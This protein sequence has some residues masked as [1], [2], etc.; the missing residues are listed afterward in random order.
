[1][2]TT[3][4]FGLQEL[5]KLTEE[6]KVKKNDIKTVKVVLA[7]TGIENTVA[8]EAQTILDRC[9]QGSEECDCTIKAIQAEDKLSE[10]ST[11]DAIAKLHQERRDTAEA[12]MGRIIAHNQNRARLDGE[13]K[14]VEKILKLFS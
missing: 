12:N 7:V 5:G 10:Q 14:R 4:K 6:V 2:V 1:M 3:T 8:K 11:N 13:R 9:C